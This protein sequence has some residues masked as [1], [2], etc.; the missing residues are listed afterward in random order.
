MESFFVREIVHMFLSSF[1]YLLF[2]E[3]FKHNENPSDLSVWGKLYIQKCRS[4]ALNFDTPTE[5]NLISKVI[6]HITMKLCQWPLKGSGN[7]S[8]AVNDESVILLKSKDKWKLYKNDQFIWNI[9]AIDFKSHQF[10]LDFC[11]YIYIYIYAWK[12]FS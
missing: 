8:N 5:V 2:S 6:K 7:Q 10:P 3:L 12:P 4:V 11:W 1:F 9:V